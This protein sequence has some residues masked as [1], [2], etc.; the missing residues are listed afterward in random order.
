[1]ATDWLAKPI[2]FY[3]VS[4]T[5]GENTRNANEFWSNK[6]ACTKCTISEDVVSSPMT[7]NASLLS[8][9]GSEAIA[10]VC[11]DESRP[12]R[13]DTRHTT[14]SQPLNAYPD[15]LKLVELL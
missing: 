9:D 8:D 1:M 5:A 3:I 12:K 7:A 4:G 14:S 15:A 10:Y 2:A 6:V 13:F 11:S